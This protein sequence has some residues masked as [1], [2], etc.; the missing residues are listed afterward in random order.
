MLCNKL[1][2]PSIDLFASRLNAQ[3]EQFVSWRPDPDAVAVDA[4]S[5]DW[6]KFE[7]YAFPPFCLKTRCLQKVNFD[8]AEG[9]LIVP[10]WPTQAWY[11]H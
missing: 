8:R 6:A 3:V 2:R 5:L 11:G 10:D 9:I 4:F 7:F 1:G